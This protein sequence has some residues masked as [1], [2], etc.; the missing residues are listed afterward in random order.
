MKLEAQRPEAFIELSEL[1][2]LLW[3]DLWIVVS[4]PLLP[5]F[6]STLEH[7]KM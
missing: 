4:P 1:L 3:L 5:V 7:L 2:D 6:L